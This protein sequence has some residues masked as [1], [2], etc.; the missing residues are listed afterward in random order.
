MPLAAAAAQP[1]LGGGEQRRQDLGVVLELEEAEHP[2][3][4][5]VVGV[6]GVVDL[7]A[8]APHD[9]PV[10]PG[11]EQLGVAVLKNA[12]MRRLRNSRRSSR[13]GGTSTER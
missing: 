6:A 2:R 5:A 12:F 10:A 13:S 3:R 11:Q 8:D 1:R 9:A 7:G 4:V